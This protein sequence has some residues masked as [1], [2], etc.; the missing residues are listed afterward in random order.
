MLPC[1]VAPTSPLHHER[2]KYA[3]IKLPLEDVRSLEKERPRGDRARG[4]FSPTSSASAF[5]H[6]TAHDQ[7][8]LRLFSFTVKVHLRRLYIGLRVNHFTRQLAASAPQHITPVITTA[9]PW[10]TVY[11]HHITAISNG[12]V[13]PRQ[14]QHT[15]NYFHTHTRRNIYT[16]IYTYINQK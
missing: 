1:S 6:G 2:I 15:L 7:T 10:I 16:Y 13:Q 3:A 12:E 4:R 9:Y 5:V 8:G 14:F 11:R